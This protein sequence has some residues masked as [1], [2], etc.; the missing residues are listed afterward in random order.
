MILVIK[1]L[2]KMLAIITFHPIIILSGQNISKNETQKL[3][4]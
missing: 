2:T 1:R 3:F 4:E